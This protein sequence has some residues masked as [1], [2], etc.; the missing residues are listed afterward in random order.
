MGGSGGFAE[1]AV[2]AADL[3]AI[4]PDQEAAAA[5]G[6]EVVLQATEVIT[7]RLDRFHGYVEKQVVRPYIAHTFELSYVSEAFKMKET[8]TPRR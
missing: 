5:G 4:V 2:T 6:V 8:T 1:Q 7:E 3:L